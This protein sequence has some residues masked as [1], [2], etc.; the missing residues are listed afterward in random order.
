MRVWLAKTSVVAEQLI[1]GER[2]RAEHFDCVTIFFSDIVH[3]TDISKQCTPLEV[4][5]LWTGPSFL[6]HLFLLLPLLILLLRTPQWGAADSE[7]KVPPDENTELKG[8]PS[9]A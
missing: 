4:Q 9:K 1:R 6:L 3:F 7:I 5:L 2:P 8:P